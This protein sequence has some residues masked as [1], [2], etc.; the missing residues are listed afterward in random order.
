MENTGVESDNSLI[1]ADR[2]SKPLHDIYLKLEIDYP[3]MKRQMLLALSTSAINDAIGPEGIVPSSLMF[4]EFQSLRSQF[5][6]IFPRPT[7][8]ERTQA[9]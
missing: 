6:L 1:I 8:A 9:A 4:R 3:Y 5:G 2:H 7:L